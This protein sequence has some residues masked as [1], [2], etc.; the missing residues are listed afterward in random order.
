MT[1]AKTEQ[2]QPPIAHGLIGAEVIDCLRWLAG[3]R[4]RYFGPLSAYEYAAEA[5]LIERDPHGLWKV[6][7]SGHVLLEA[8]R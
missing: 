3:D 2:L 5:G 1:D 6:S 8:V 4:P 7:D